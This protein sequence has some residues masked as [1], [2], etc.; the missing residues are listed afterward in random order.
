MNS[1]QQ[2]S[3]SMK[4]AFDYLYK[5]YFGES[6]IE[7]D[8]IDRLPEFLDGRDVFIDVGASLGMYTYFAN[9]VMTNGLIIAIEAD[10][11]RY[12]ELEKNCKKWQKESTNII[13]PLFSAAGDSH[14]GLSFYKTES[15]ISGGVF[16][17]PERAD[18]FVEVNVSQLML[19]DFY[20][21]GKKYFVKI[22]VEGAECRVLEGAITLI[23]SGDTSLAVGIHSWGDKERNKTPMSVLHFMFNKRMAISK[24]S[25]HMTANYL[26][27]PAESGKIV[28]FFSYCCYAPMLLF[29]QV[30]R[31]FVPR[32]LARK[33]EKLFNR[34]RRKKIIK[35]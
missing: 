26:F 20:E 3:D 34:I 6:Q 21:E 30:Y 25:N 15:H 4:E 5:T 28:L 11:D 14:D 1:P 18:N 13:K 32:T 35:G 7:K 10:P 29:R 17:I 27:S 24:T 16:E 33:I 19:D 22:D 8:E 9:K 2:D 12:D 31:K 23:D